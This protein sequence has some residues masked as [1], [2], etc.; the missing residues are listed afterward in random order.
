MNGWILEVVQKSLKEEFDK[1]SLKERN[2]LIEVGRKMIK[3][4]DI[5]NR[6]K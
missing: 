1:Y 4:G 2:E 5:K 6:P 3:S